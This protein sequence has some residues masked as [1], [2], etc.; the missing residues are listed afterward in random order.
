MFFMTFTIT[1]T[2]K[3][4]TGKTIL[5]TLIL[6]HMLSLFKE[7]SFLVVDA[8]SN[9][10]LN[11]AL[12]ISFEKTIGDL[13][14]EFLESESSLAGSK[15]L[16]FETLLYEEVLVEA[17]RYDFIAMGRPEGPG[18]YCYVNHLLRHALDK[19][20]RNY[21]FVIID[22]EA[23]LEHLSRRTT[24]NVDVMLITVDSSLRS[25]V[26]AERIKELASKLEV[27]VG[28][29]YIVI[30]RASR[31]IIPRI[32]EEIIKRDFKIIGAIPE[33]PNVMEYD[34]KGE[35]I[36]N[37]PDDSPAVKA[38]REIVERLLPLIKRSM[39]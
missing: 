9:T 15:D 18:C 37:L 36:I 39:I 10:N 14:E 22:C 26:T 27:L 13:R 32:L 16:Q 31:T 19:L 23:G 34:L 1:I 17:D 4:G 28:E 7:S 3:G 25:I 11:K 6:R 24:R 35:P 12:G 38:T 20:S 29:M 33:D 8:D 2:G 30:N 21:D 5:A